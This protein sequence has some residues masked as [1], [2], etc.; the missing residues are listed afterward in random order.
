MP[1]LFLATLLLGHGAITS[2]I[3]LVS[4]A[5]ALVCIAIAYRTNDR[6]LRKIVWEMTAT[7]LLTP[8]LDVLAGSCSRPGSAS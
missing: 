5:L 2:V 3:A 8:I 4:L 7:I 1:S 6:L